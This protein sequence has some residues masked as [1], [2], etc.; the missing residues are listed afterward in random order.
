M[1][2]GFP[3]EVGPEWSL[4]TISHDIGKA[5]HSST[6]SSES[7]AFCKKEILERTQWGFSIIFS[8]TK[9]LFVTSLFISRL[10]LADQVNRRPR[11]ICNSN[12]EPNAATPSVNSSTD[13]GTVPNEM[14]FGACVAHILQNIWDAEPVDGLV[15]LS[16]WDILDAFYRCNLRPSDIGKFLYVLLCINMVLPMDWLTSPDF[17]CAASDMVT[18]NANVYALD[19]DSNFL[20][21]PPPTAGA[22]KT[23]NSATASPNR[24]QYIDVYME[25]LLCASQE[26]PTQQQRVSEITIRALKEI[27]PSLLSEV[28]DSASLKK[29]LAG[30]GD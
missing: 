30:D 23:A 28:K 10:T 5:P 11:L 17:F 25:D 19:P 18:D 7:T 29:A 22:Y 20:V 9:A 6:L 24:L 27:F 16:K 1:A 2:N 26:N 3:V 15:W 14:Q 8:V 12:K 21:Y 4:E 13:K